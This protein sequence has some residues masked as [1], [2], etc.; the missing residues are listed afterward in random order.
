MSC[1]CKEQ[2]G[3]CGVY[4]CI[5]VEGNKGVWACHT[6]KCIYENVCKSINFQVKI[7]PEQGRRKQLAGMPCPVSRIPHPVF[8][9]RIPLFRILVTSHWPTSHAVA[10]RE[11][12]K[13]LRNTK[14][15]WQ[16]ISSANFILELKC[17]THSHRTHTHTHSATL[18]YSGK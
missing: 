4:L 11:V 10:P 9:I 1:N 17:H 6:P 14:K 12:A 7:P 3:N 18:P 8:R 2:W 5:F 13:T 15:C 16:H